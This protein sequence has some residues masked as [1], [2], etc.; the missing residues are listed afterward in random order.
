MTNKLSLLV[1]GALFAA[2]GTAQGQD[3]VDFAKQVQPL[4]AETCYSCHGPEKQK[5]ELRLDNLEAFKKGGESGAVITAG[6]PVK[7]SLLTRTTLPAD[8]DDIMP[9]KGDPL[10]KEQTDLINKWIA[11]GANFG[12]WKG[13]ATAAGPAEVKLPEVPAADAAVLEKVR[14]TGALAM[15]LA[16]GINLLDVSFQSAAEKTT[17]AE[18]ALLT[19]VA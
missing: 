3:K 5:G 12:E 7:S 2:A 11:E 9:P 18:L 19:P 10:K 8:H 13:D 14:G 1:A 4:L 17:D 15:P 16:Q 6:D